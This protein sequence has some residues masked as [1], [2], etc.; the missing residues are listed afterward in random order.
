[1][2]T[3][4]SFGLQLTNQLSATTMPTTTTT[5]SSSQP[6]AASESRDQLDMRVV[7]E[8]T[9]SHDYDEPS[10]RYCVNKN[11]PGPILTTYY[12]LLNR[13]QSGPAASC[14]KPD[15]VIEPPAQSPSVLRTCARPFS[16]V[17]LPS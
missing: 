1:M 2:K 11:R 3:S 8:M 15:Q 12:L 7:R 10:I 9:S 13:I 16:V 6:A 5:N 17:A 4:S 14:P